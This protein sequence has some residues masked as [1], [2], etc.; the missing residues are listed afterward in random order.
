MVESSTLTINLN[1]QASL[2]QDSTAVYSI[3]KDELV[4][5]VINCSDTD[6]VE[7]QFT[8]PGLQPV[9]DELVNTSYEP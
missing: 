8:L 1:I 5:P 2:S 3:N 6:V 7:W 9:P 4:I